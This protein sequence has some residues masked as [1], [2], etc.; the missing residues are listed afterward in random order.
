MVDVL[1]IS[2]YSG[3]GKSTLIKHVLNCFSHMKL[4]VSC[5][6]RQPRNGERDGRE[7]YFL[8]K[9]KF[10]KLI[11]E[12]A[13]IEYVECFGNYYGTLKSEVT[14]IIKSGNTCILDIEFKGAYNVL[15][16]HVLGENV[17]CV[18]ILIEP[19]SIDELK[20]RLINR[21]E[22]IENIENRTKNLDISKYYKI[23]DK[24]ITN[25]DLQQAKQDITKIIRETM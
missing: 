24:K 5:T 16:K 11:N 19:P 3:S 22:T 10:D 14:H 6:T 17:K 9:S 12:N 1:V 7:Y 2:G 23:F 15:V 20:S 18:G 21:G 13:F 25:D 8:D 4:S